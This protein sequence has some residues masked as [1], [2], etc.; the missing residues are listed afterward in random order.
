MSSKGPGLSEFLHKRCYGLLTI[1][2]L[3]VLAL[4][5]FCSL[6]VDQPA[7]KARMFL[8]VLALERSLMVIAILRF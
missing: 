3:A 5:Q 6:V 8:Q 2:K 1:R 4:W 7:E